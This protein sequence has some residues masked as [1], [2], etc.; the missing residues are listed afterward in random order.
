MS[1]L[2]LV[3]TEARDETRSLVVAASLTGIAN[4]S[5]MSL[6][7]RA[8][9]AE[10]DDQIRYF[11]M[12]GLSVVLYVI[13][14]RRTFHRT[15]EI[16]ESALQKIKLRLIEKIEQAELQELEGIG[17]SVVYDRLTEN[18]SAISEAAGSIANV[19]QSFC[20]LVF[21]SF[22]VLS[23]SVPG[24]ALL[25]LLDVVGII[26][27]SSKNAEIR[28]HLA[29]AAQKRV[30]FLDQLTD[31][32]KGA[33]EVRFSQK[34]SADIRM[35]LE[36]TAE[37][38][39]LATIKANNLFNDNHILS[40]CVL[41][42]LLVAVVFALPQHVPMEA[43]ALTTLVGGVLF[44]WGP[45]GGVVGGMPVYMR[46]NNALTNIYALEAKID[47]ATKDH[48]LAAK[49]EDPWRGRFSSIDVKNVSFAYPPDIGGQTF[50]IGPMNLSIS[51][52]EVVFIVGGNGSGKSTFMKVLTGLYSPASGDVR[53]DGQ[54]LRPE[55]V[56]AYREMFSVIFSD[57]HLF[58]RLYGLLDVD[59]QKVLGLL[60]QM[61]IR[62][63]TSFEKGS[64]TKR[65]LSTGQRKRLAMIVAMLEDRPICVFDEWAAD[66][67]PEFRKY[68][69]DEIIPSLKRRGK[70]VIAVSHDDRYF[71]CSDRVV[72]L[73][74]GQVR[75]IEVVTKAVEGNGEKSP[76]SDIFSSQDQAAE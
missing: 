30:T 14:A 26:L 29:E 56:A 5:I 6:V 67:D 38:L 48:V 42:A 51:A 11:V 7:N 17:T 57:F 27:W 18:I 44:F 74:Y 64:F 63:K 3:R 13:C 40:Q 24:F 52:G 72:T 75:S 65:D 35:D 54:R 43:K 9:S 61:Q 19:L 20:I 59:E 21:A 58:S 73:E 60:Q 37:D 69:Y 50:R 8:A 4:A 39:R 36:K 34:R 1:L 32:L 47:Q 12:V 16:I 41:F 15:T 71:H 23:I 46:S 70:T 25:V 10:Q 68:F 53:M 55:N 33:K 22:Y 28:Q 62:D 49:A 76:S 45:L 31:L 66:Q 2:D